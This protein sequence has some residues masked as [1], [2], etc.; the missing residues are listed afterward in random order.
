MTG[1]VVT[2]ALAA[3]LYLFFARKRSSSAASARS[4]RS[5][6][7]S[8][9]VAAGVWSALT[10]VMLVTVILVGMAQVWSRWRHRLLGAGARHRRKRLHRERPGRREHAVLSRAHGD[11]PRAAGV[12]AASEA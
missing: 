4:R 2:L 10:L 8:A 1:V 12:I 9:V 7:A 5:G 11:T 6:A 3:Q